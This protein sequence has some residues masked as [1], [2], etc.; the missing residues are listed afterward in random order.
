MLSTTCGTSKQQVE[1]H[2]SLEDIGATLRR[3]T[4]TKRSKILSDYVVYLQESNY[5]IG[6]KN[7]PKFFSRAMSCKESKLWY[8]AMKDGMSSMR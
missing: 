2:T 8:N 4:R 5:N 6:A 1:P 7:D 3:S